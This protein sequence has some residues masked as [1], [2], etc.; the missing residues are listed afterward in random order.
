MSVAKQHAAIRQPVDVWRTS[1]WMS[2]QTAK[3]IVQ[4]IHRDE[5]DVG[6]SFGFGLVN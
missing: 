2:S 6:G 3:P 5:Q 1:L 4:V